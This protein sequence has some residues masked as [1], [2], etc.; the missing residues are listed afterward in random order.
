MKK[1]A[2]AIVATLICL[3]AMAG[4]TPDAITLTWSRSDVS[5]YA[6]TTNVYLS[7]VT[8]RATN[9]VAHITPAVGT[10]VAAVAQD[11]T[12]LTVTLRA[13]DAGTNLAYTAHVRSGTNG[14]FD[15]DFKFPTWTPGPTRQT[16]GQEGLELTIADTNT[17][18]SVTYKGRKL[19]NVMQPLH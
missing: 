19:F 7:G 10:N 8:Y 15:V 11:L 13:G 14:L 9:C 6:D 2:A 5:E 18:T 17:A 1:A 16:T 3:A 12:G 4:L